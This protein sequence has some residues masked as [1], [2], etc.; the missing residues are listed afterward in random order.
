MAHRYRG[1]SLMVDVR[2]DEQAV[3]CDLPAAVGQ[4]DVDLQYGQN[5]DLLLSYRDGRTREQRRIGVP[6][7]TQF[8]EPERAV[9]NN[10]VLS[11]YFAE[12]SQ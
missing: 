3:Y 4:D 12:D 5:N 1:D 8:L 9:F 7:D 6:E 2:A 11:V 10:G